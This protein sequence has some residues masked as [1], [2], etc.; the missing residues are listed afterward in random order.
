MDIR[1]TNFLL[2]NDS[3]LV[4]KTV[5]IFDAEFGGV[6]QLRGCK[7]ARRSNGDLVVATPVSKQRRGKLEPTAWFIDRKMHRLFYDRAVAAYQALAGE[8]ASA[9]GF[10]VEDDDTGLQRTLA[11]TR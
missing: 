3:S 4:P 11:V 7:V 2:V 6:I 1:F 8:G 9:E 10:A 5:G